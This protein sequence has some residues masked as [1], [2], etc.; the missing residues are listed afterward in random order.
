MS[1]EAEDFSGTEPALPD[2]GRAV[3]RSRSE[4]FGLVGSPDMQACKWL[5]AYVA[6][7]RWRV[8]AAALSPANGDGGFQPLDGLYI[9][10]GPGASVRSGTLVGTG[11]SALLSPPSS[12][13]LFSIVSIDDFAPSGP[14]SRI[15]LCW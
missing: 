8:N 14:V 12:R 4:E 2:P 10:T 9:A 3:E 5:Q 11:F 1:S 7:A 6:L 15:S 13:N